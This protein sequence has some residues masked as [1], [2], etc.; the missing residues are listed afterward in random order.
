MAVNMLNGARY[1]L[2]CLFC[3]LPILAFCD[4]SKP[5]ITLTTPYSARVGESAAVVVYIA[6]PPK[7]KVDLTMTASSDGVVFSEQKFSLQGPQKKFLEVTFKTAPPSGLVYIYADANG[8]ESVDAAIDLGFAGHLKPTWS[9]TLTSDASTTIAL[10][11]A[12]RDGKSIPVDGDLDATVETSDGILN[13]NRQFVPLALLIPS[14]SRATPQ[15]RLK[16]RFVRG[17]NVH[18]SVLLSVHDGKHVLAQDQFVFAAQPAWWLPVCLALLG[19]VLHAVYKL[20]R[21]PADRVALTAGT[22]IVVTSLIASL[23]GYLFADF[24]L[25]GLKLDPNVLRTYPLVGFLFS[26]LGIEA[27]LS[28]RLGGTRKGATTADT[29]ERTPEA[30]PN[31]IRSDTITSIPPAD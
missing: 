23:I 3:L 29:E 28:D 16:P 5:S 14:G 9:A 7:N 24:D 6:P 17:G 10:E 31:E 2:L 20:V 4:E 25:L 22:V 1:S 30:K 21:M 13:D 15:F 11:I 27:L 12:D 26:Y 19:G 18:L 8:F